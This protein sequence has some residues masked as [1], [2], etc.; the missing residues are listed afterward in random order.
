[1]TI[2]GIFSLRERPRKEMFLHDINLAKIIPFT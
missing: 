1:M 2:G